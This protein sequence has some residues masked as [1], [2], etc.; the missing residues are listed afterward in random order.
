MSDIL[1]AFDQADKQAGQPASSSNILDAFDQANK[2]ASATPAPA[3]PSTK[4]QRFG[5]GLLDLPYKASQ[6]F[7]HVLPD[8]AADTVN[9]VNKWLASKT[10]TE[11]VPVQDVD[12]KVNQR[13][14]EYQGGRAAAGSNGFDWMR[15]AGNIANPV[16]YIPLV[17]GATAATT[18]G[19]V[20]VGAAN[21]AYSAVLSTP[22]TGEDQKDFWGSQAKTATIGGLMGGML[23]AGAEAA[24]P[25]VSKAITK[26]NSFVRGTSQESAANAVKMV[27]QAFA[28]KGINPGSIDPSI[29]AQFVKQVQTALD[30]GTSVDSKTLE[31]LAEAASLPVPVPMLKGQASRDPMQFAQE[32]NLRGIQGTGEPIQGVMQAQNRALVENLDHM[33]ARN[34]PNIVDAGQSAI[35]TIKSIDDQARQSVSAAYEKFRQATGRDLDV[36]MSGIAQDYARTL[37]DF[38]ETIPGAVRKRFE[39]Y[40]LMNG[41]QTKVFSIGDAED[42]IK[43]INKNYDPANR[44]QANA[45]DELRK[46]VQNAITT[47]A[48]VGEGGEAAE[49]AKQ[50]RMMAA[51]R[52]KLIEA[53]PGYKAAISGAAPDDF[54]KKYFW[55][56]KSG[57]IYN[58]KKVLASDPS[59]LSDVKSAIVGQLKDSA[60]NKQ[61][62]ANGI[63]SQAAYNKIIRD[64]NNVKRFGALFEPEEFS[65]LQRLG[66]VAENVLL[67]PKASAVNRSNTASAAANMVQ[68][69]AQGG[70]GTKALSLA[71]KANIPVAS[72]LAG[73]AAGRSGSSTLADLV[74][75]STQPLTANDIDALGFMTRYSG[76][77]GGAAAGSAQR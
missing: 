36:P 21:G 18:L 34:A 19:R 45:L 63:F 73:W 41:N 2:A 43:T 27:D 23:T 40:G 53:V 17:R 22:T 24:S 31:N 72:P 42:L 66:N 61:S 47:G 44:A 68:T 12:N 62:D 57:E 32:M 25:Y 37:S 77:A 70:L 69:A 71:S 52:F 54:I 11:Y 65:G 29:R 55:Q 4:M 10:G 30:T 7:S 5:S 74:R 8:G 60:I 15:L 14:Q 1:D 13:E 76:Q 49:L 38:G 46:S 6:L 59:T 58:L 64:Q 16:N 56:G 33:G 26:L 20:G 67:E 39:S 51:Q 48:G 28:S 50:A 35:N 3:T 75:K 9:N